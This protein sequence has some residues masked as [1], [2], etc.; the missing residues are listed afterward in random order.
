MIQTLYQRFVHWC[1][2]SRDYAF[3]RDWKYNVPIWQSVHLA[4]IVLLLSTTVILNLRL[5]N[6]GFKR[7]PLPLLAKQ[8]WPWTKT[9]IWLAVVSG[10]MVFLPDPTRYVNSTP[11]RVKLLLFLVALLYQFT[12]FRKVV[13]TD[14]EG[15]SRMHNAA[16]AGVSLMLWYGVSWSGRA[17]AFFQ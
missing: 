12:V 1:Y 9:G 8:L 13:R 7:L 2:F 17:I 5:L 4:G 11:F 16:I 15:Y 3:L 10:I 14:P 6:M